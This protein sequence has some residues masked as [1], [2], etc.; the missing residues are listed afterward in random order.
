LEDDVTEVVVTGLES[1]RL[2]A[3]SHKEAEDEDEKPE[4]VI[5]KDKK[6]SSN[7]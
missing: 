4:D 6:E 1:R 3:H 2:L 7:V 5:T